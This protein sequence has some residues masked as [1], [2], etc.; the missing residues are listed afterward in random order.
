MTVFVTGENQP[1][2]TEWFAAI[3]NVDRSN[4]FREEDN[5][6]VD[7]LEVLFQ[8]FGLQYERPDIL[9]ARALADG[10]AEFQ[11]ILATKGDELCAIRLVPNHPE[12]PKIRDRGQTLRNCYE[13]WFKTQTIN[14]DDYTA[15]ICPHTNELIWSLIFV[16]TKQ[17]RKSVV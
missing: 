4:K 15:Y 3:G 5:R 16:I 2:M 10:V 1:S 11:N 9:P 12:L 7:R 17:D 13:N 6:K 8:T 14:P